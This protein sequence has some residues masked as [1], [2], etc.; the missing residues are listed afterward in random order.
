MNLPRGVRRHDPIDG[1]RPDVSMD[2][3]QELSFHFKQMIQALEE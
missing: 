3:D 2:V 1:D